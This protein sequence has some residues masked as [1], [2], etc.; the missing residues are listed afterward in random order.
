MNTRVLA[1]LL[2]LALLRETSGHGRPPPGFARPLGPRGGPL[3]PP[4][5]PPR[6]PPPPPGGALA[7]RPRPPGGATVISRKTETLVVKSGFGA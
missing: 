6:P 3:P 5:P 7:F 2:V 1:L 4:P